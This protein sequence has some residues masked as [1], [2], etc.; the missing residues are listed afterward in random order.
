MAMVS[1]LRVLRSRP[2]RDQTSP[3]ATSVVK[4]WKS[5][6]KDVAFLSDVST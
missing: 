2:G 4:S 6:L 5:V 3:Q 1:M